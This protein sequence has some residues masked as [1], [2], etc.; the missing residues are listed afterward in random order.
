MEI[1]SRQKI[2]KETLVLN[3]TLNQMDLVNEQRNHIQ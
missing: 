2:S 1:S 3:D